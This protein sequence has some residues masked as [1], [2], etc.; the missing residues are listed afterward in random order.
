MCIWIIMFFFNYYV[1]KGTD[2]NF[3]QFYLQHKQTIIFNIRWMSIQSIDLRVSIKTRTLAFYYKNQS[4][5]NQCLKERNYA[6]EKITWCNNG[7]HES[8]SRYKAQTSATVIVRQGVLVP[9]TR[10]E[11][12]SWNFRSNTGTFTPNTANDF[13]ST[14]MASTAESPTGSTCPCNIR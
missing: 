11:T 10:M 9:H 2:I 8:Y 1:L 14:S 5:V 4:Y 7:F 13:K 6:F 12:N 3:I